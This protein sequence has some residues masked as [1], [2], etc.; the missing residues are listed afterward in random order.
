MWA[1]GLWQF[2]PF[3]ITIV[4]LV[5]TDLL[6]GIM[7]GMIVAVFEILIYNYQLNFYREVTGPGAMTIRLSE[8]M[9]FLNKA[10]L[11]RILREVPRGYSLTIDM[12]ATRILDH[13]VHEVI[14]DFVTH[15]KTDGI[16]LV[17][18]GATGPQVSLT[19]SLPEEPQRDSLGLEKAEGA[20]SSQS[21]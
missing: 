4:G 11:K 13:D 9:T 18:K 10:G 2:A 21:A 14:R 6:T 8:H 5:L 3:M 1:E 7:L 12:T 20:S 17:I 15:A 16:E 19:R